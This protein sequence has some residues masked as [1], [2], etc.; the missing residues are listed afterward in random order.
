MSD[1]GWQLY[2]ACWS[3]D[4]QKA[5]QL[6][7]NWDQQRIQDA[8]QYENG[9]V[10]MLFGMMLCDIG[11]T[12]NMSLD[13]VTLWYNMGHILHVCI[14]P[15]WGDTPLHE[16]CIN[17]HDKV[18]EMLL[19]HGVDAEAKNHVSFFLWVHYFSCVV[20]TLYERSCVCV[21]VC[22]GLHRHN[23]SLCFCNGWMHHLL[24]MMMNQ[25]T[26]WR[27]TTARCLWKRSC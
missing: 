9:W 26:E 4:P 18:V 22:R 20:I 5:L 23:C 8:A 17:G 10:R 11:Y 16:A 14:I 25:P 24:T 13:G 15:Q 19:K 12:L 21:H 6:L 2:V 7:T 1:D 3:S 27:V